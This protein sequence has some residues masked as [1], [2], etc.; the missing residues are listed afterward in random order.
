MLPM[1]RTAFPLSLIEA[2]RQDLAKVQIL[3]LMSVFVWSSLMM[4]ASIGWA[5][6]I[7]SVTSMQRIV[8]PLPQAG[9]TGVADDQESSDR[10]R[11]DNGS[12]L[13]EPPKLPLHL[14]TEVATSPP[15]SARKAVAA[16]PVSACLPKQNPQRLPPA[17]QAIGANPQPTKLPTR[18]SAATQ[19]MQPA[20]NSLERLPKP[21][22]L[23]KPR[24]LPPPLSVPDSSV[25]EFSPWQP[26]GI[27]PR[28]TTAGG[29]RQVGYWEEL[30]SSFSTGTPGERAGV[31]G[32]DGSRYQVSGF[33][34]TNAEQPLTLTLS[35]E[36]WGEGT[37]NSHVDDFSPTT[38][39]VEPDFHDSVA[40]QSV[41]DDKHAVPTQRPWIEWGRRFYGSGITPPSET[42]LG[43][44]NLI[45]QQLYLY[46][47]YRTGISTGRND[48]GRIDNW[49]SRLNLDLDYRLTAT[50][51]F[52]A[53]VG[54]LN[55]ATQF[56]R[57]ERNGDDWQYQEFYNLNPVT[58]YFE[59]DAGALLGGAAGTPS[60][61]ELPVTAGLVPLLFQNGVWMEDA[62]SGVAFAIPAKHSRALNWA[63]FDATF[64]ALFDQINSPAFGVDNHAAQA[65]GTA[66]FIDAYGGYIETGYAYLNDRERLGRSYHNATFS[67]TRRYFDRISN[68]VRVIVNAGQDLPTANRTA[69][70]TL[71]LVENSLV[72]PAP[73]TVV[74]YF[75]IFAGW[76]R[77]QSVARAGVAGGVL[78]NTGI[79]YEIDGLNGYPTLDATGADT[80]GG[81][82]GL[83][84]IGKDFDR[85]WIVEASYLTPHGT[86]SSANG[87]QYA[88][89]TRYQ[90]GISHRSIIRFDT[91]YGW[92]ENK[93]DI[94]GSRLEYRWKF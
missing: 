41:Y 66:W 56:T 36:Y 15:K 14:P 17:N 90:I 70:G 50:E 57:L 71:L 67:F 80:A 29:F 52:H 11:C 8:L 79:N 40:E 10:N 91:M 28:P 76:G 87:E 25:P 54:P 81:S 78:R 88:L 42:W 93:G 94:Y 20:L 32:T 73:Y 77:P 3:V 46:G 34:T 60:P 38:L 6:E 16:T 64:F 35:P 19:V 68:S 48:V 13:D 63:N 37:V 92:R 47:D 45:Q 84:L 74:P 4:I 26:P 24:R 75:N 69:D 83:D 49:A 43:D 21:A 82:I 62:A 2:A 5:A 58:A 86:R 55:R 22:P 61:F 33:T 53:F 9:L 72:T 65:F 30:S 23:A 12:T 44:T 27:F 89:G 31:R 1:S 39:P 85:Q 7:P 18:E 59:G 51:R